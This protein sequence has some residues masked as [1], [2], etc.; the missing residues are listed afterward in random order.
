MS[1]QSK[2]Q[3]LVKEF[4]GQKWYERDEEERDK[5]FAEISTLLVEKMEKEKVLHGDEAYW[6]EMNK[7]IQMCQDIVK[8]E[9]GG[10][11]E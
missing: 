6:G 5:L 11:D 2:I 10:G 7:T 4:M 8:R 9:C 3:E 1:K